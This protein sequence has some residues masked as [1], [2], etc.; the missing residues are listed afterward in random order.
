MDSDPKAGFN[1]KLNCRFASDTNY[2]CTVKW[3]ANETM[4][5]Q[6][7]RYTIQGTLLQFKVE[8]SDR[9]NNFS[10]QV[11]DES[12]SLRS[13]ALQLQPKCK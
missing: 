10:C 2:T 4:L 8:K 1:I 12:N 7:P 13:E 6:G 11:V 9:Y 3:Y 5:T